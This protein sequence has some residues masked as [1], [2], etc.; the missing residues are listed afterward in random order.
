MNQTE[1]KSKRKPRTK[2]AEL[3]THY[4]S[5]NHKYEIGIDE[6]GRGPLFGRLY[7]AGV[8]L[9]KDGSVNMEH[10]RDSK[11]SLK[12]DWMK[13]MIMYEKRRSCIILNM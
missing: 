10:I 7:V 8:V 4:D 11:N 9:P 3:P 12:R 5:E 13:C 6:A 2:P 1:E